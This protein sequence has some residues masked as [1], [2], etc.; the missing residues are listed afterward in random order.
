MNN[1]SRKS[2]NG[3]RKPKPSQ[4]GSSQDIQSS[5]IFGKGSMQE[6]LNTSLDLR[7]TLLVW[8][9][10]YNEIAN[11]KD[12]PE[13]P[14][15]LKSID[16]VLWGL[17]KRE[18]IVIGGR[19]SQG[20]SAFAIQMAKNLADINKRIIYFSLEMS[21][22]QLIERMFC[23]ICEV[24]NIH[25]RQ[26]KAKQE[27]ENKRGIFESIVKDFKLLIDDK[28]GYNFDKLIKVCEIIKPDFIFIDYITMISAQGYQSKTIAIEE[29]IRK[30]KQLTMDMNL[31]AIVLSQ[32]NRSGVDNPDMSKL[33]WAGVL[34]E[35]PD[36]VVTLK[37]DWQGGK[38]I[39]NVHI[40]KQRH[41]EVKNVEV[42]F[43][44]QYSKFRDLSKDEQHYKEVPERADFI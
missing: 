36:T 6:Q 9:D 12:K 21:R 40:E 27:L 29:Y 26:G 35:H 16:D 14:I 10:L 43:I 39:Y 3:S 2:E 33:K 44:P 37:W 25:L 18:L 24:N 42:K 23:N 32:I 34:E 5:E 28:Y 11:R 1:L 4:N 30:L 13:Y 20:K 8:N 38:D 22:E 41:G 19:P 31:G 15:G 7:P 17:H